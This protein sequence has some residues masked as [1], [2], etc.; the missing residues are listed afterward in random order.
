MSGGC[1]ILLRKKTHRGWVQRPPQGPLKISVFYPKFSKNHKIFSSL[2]LVADIL[3]TTVQ[4]SHKP[5]YLLC[6]ASFCCCLKNNKKRGLNTTGGAGL[7]ATPATR[8]FKNMSFYSKFI[9][10]FAF[11]WNFVKSKKFMRCLKFKNPKIWWILQNLQF[12]R[13]SGTTFSKIPGNCEHHNS[14]KCKNIRVSRKSRGE[15]QIFP[16]KMST[17]ISD[18]RRNQGPT[19]SEIPG[20]CDHHNA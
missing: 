8:T 20:N 9:K 2:L 3:Q 18:F 11:F 15:N 5:L 19:F 16:R 7:S 10:K 17:T 4:P 6:S 1:G 12:S 14:Q 13:K